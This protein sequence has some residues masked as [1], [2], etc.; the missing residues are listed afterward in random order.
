MKRVLKWVLITLGGLGSVVVVAACVV[1]VV[2]SRKLSARH[3]IAAESELVVPTDSA[4]I[5]RGARLVGAR[6]CG[7]CH[8]EDYGGNTIGDNFLFGRIVPPNLTNG[9]GGRRPPRTNVEWERAIR[10]G[11]R[12]DGTSLVIMPSASFHAI[13][14]DEM[15]AM[16]AYLKQIPTVDRETPPMRS[17]PLQRLLL[18]AGMFKTSA[19]EV[20]AVPHVATVD[21]TPG[22]E[23]GTYLVASTGCRMCHGQSLSGG[24]AP[25]AG[26]PPFPNLTPIGIGHYSEDDFKRT[27]RTGRRPSGGPELNELMPWK[28]F[29]TLTDDQL[30]SIWLVLK[31]LPPKQFGEK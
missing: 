28:Y 14:D 26:E 7:L 24:P 6:P 19:E 5:A 25:V 10:H 20:P 3:E 23:Y 13:A 1:Y 11:V 18:A 4:S 8:G 30:H 29:R 27:L 21:T 15:A 17:G 2:G 12:R 22:L 16:I 31:S 9:R